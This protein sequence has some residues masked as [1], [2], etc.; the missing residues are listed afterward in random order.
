MRHNY[1]QSLG[2]LKNPIKT[3]KHVANWRTTSL[4]IFDLKTISTFLGTQQ[5]KALIMLIKR[6]M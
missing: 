2:L 1:K 4:L 6:P 3:K 5:Q